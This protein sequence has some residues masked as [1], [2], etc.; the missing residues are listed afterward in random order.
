MV[1]LLQ[2]KFIKFTEESGDCIVATQAAL[3]AVQLTQLFHCPAEIKQYCS[4]P[5]P[6]ET[7]MTVMDLMYALLRDGWEDKGMPTKSPEC[8]PYKAGSKRVVYYHNGSLLGKN[9]LR[10]LRNSE[11]IL[12]K[13]GISQSG[14]HYWQSEGYYRA[15]LECTAEN[16]HLVKPQLKLN[17]Y[18]RIMKGLA[19][20]DA[21]LDLHGTGSRTDL[22]LEDEEGASADRAGDGNIMY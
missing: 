7:D 17:D 11:E 1:Q 10:A 5:E 20:S 19:P 9:Y 14:I 16:S 13:P 4:D 6:H 21:K 2:L 8:I 12:K 15:L 3:K 22:Q 18:K